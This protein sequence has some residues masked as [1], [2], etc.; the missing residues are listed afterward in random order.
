MIK[1]IYYFLHKML[2]KKNERGEYSAG[3]WQHTVREQVIALCA[4]STGKL[5]EVGCGEGLLLS[6]IAKLNHNLEIHGIDIWDEILE[7]AQERFKAGNIQGV[8]LQQADAAKLPYA[9][10]YFDVVICIN[11]FFNLPSDTIFRA[12]LKEISRVCKE[13]AIFI[14]DIRNCLNPL[15]YFKYKLARFYDETVANL[16]LRTYN[17]SKVQKNL[18][19]NGFSILKKINIGF[20][21]NQ[22][23]PIFVIKAKKEKNKVIV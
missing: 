5:L 17:F 13:N 23:S 10:R 1:K 3:V 18:A 19:E 12:S 22:F 15:L 11:V 21:R 20:P 7:R 14:F 6:E 2:S 16:P 4:Q 9:D 8:K